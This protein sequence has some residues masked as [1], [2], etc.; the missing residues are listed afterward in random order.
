M[1]DESRDYDGPPAGYIPREFREFIERDLTDDEARA[2]QSS[3]RVFDCDTGSTRS[4]TVEEIKKKCKKNLGVRDTRNGAITGTH[5]RLNIV[6]VK[7][8]G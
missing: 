7:F 8:G 6:T 4:M 1:S 2:L 3:M 5:S